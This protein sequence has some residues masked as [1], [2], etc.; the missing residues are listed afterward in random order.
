MRV[1]NRTK[2][3]LGVL[4]YC[5]ILALMVLSTNSGAHVGFGSG[6]IRSTWSDVGSLLTLLIAAPIVLWAAYQH[7]NKP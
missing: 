1:G 3:A 5:A 2:V 6:R 7:W 4:L